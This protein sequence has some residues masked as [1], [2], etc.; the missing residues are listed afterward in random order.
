VSTLER[1][2]A[3]PVPV[4]DIFRVSDVAGLAAELEGRRRVS[5]VVGA[6]EAL[7]SVDREEADMY[8]VLLPL[9]KGNPDREA[10]FCVH[11]V[12]GLSW[13]YAG[14]VPHVDPEIGIYG[15]QSPA[16]TEPDYRAVSIRRMASRYVE[17]IKQVQ[18]HGPYHLVGWS[19]GG[20]IAH[21]IAVQLQELGDEVAALVLL[22]SYLDVDKDEIYRELNAAFGISL[23]DFV[24]PG[25][26]SDALDEFHRRV[27]EFVGESLAPSLQQL[28]GLTSAAVE[29]ARLIKEHAP[30]VF[31]GNM[32]YFAAQEQGEDPSGAR[33]WRPHVDGT[34]DIVPL[35][36]T[37]DELGT[38]RALGI[39]GDAVNGVLTGKEVSKRDWRTTQE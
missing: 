31:S 8:G 5:A 24:S 36:F 23:S 27:V 25:G 33:Q 7:D 35:P 21:E 4:G 19:L 1:K 13:S 39:V 34:I 17:E 20:V 32:V 26:T 14:L 2:L 22:D 29:A 15:L 30:R 16:A 37:H 6:T 3:V 10:L 11:P 9:R 18:K 38:P 28:R 12:R